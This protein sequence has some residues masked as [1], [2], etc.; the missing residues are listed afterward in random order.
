M[1]EISDFSDTAALVANLDVIV[2]VDTSTAHLS[3]ALGKPTWILNRF[4]SCWR[5]LLEREDSPWYQSVKL[6]R[7]AEDQLWQPVL[8]RVASDLTKLAQ[9]AS[10]A[11]V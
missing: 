9:A 3:A 2:S 7:Q 11:S 5:W 8:R 1:D 10:T 4:D 6:Y